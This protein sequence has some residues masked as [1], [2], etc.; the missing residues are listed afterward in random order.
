MNDLFE[1]KMT[2]DTDG[3]EGIDSRRGTS[4]E[5]NEVIS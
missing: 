4:L 2:R 1:G 3:G 5:C